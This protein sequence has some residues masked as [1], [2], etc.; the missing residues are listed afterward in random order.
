[1][2]TSTQLYKDALPFPHRR[3]TRVEV[4]HGGVRV[5]DSD[6]DP[7]LLPEA[8]SVSASLTSRV[9]RTMDLEVSPELYPSDPADLLSPYTAVL[10]VSSGIGYPDGS[11]E[12]FPVFTGRVLDV[13]R[14]ENGNVV[15]RCE[16]LAADVIG[17]QFEQPQ[18]SILGNPITSEIHRLILQALPS[19]TFGTDDVVDS[20]TPTLVWDE[21]RGQ[22]LDDLA[23]AVKA[24]WYA[25]GDG[26]FVIRR[27]PYTAGVPVA[28]LVDQSGGLVMTASRSVTRAG[29]ANSVTV[30]SERMDGTAPVRATARDNDP[31]SPTYFGG[32]YGKVSQII[33][34]QTPL[35]NSEAQ[36]LAIAQLAAC[37]AL[38]EQWSISCTPDHT[39]E[40][41]DTINASYRG[42]SAVQVI[43]RIT[44]PLT[45]EGP[46]ELQCRSS[47]PEPVIS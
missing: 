34:V 25:L 37:I 44:Y 45:T 5:G 46:M 18:P 29:S 8:G 35:T 15:L 41:G 22:A 9:T 16:D 39:L 13:D 40:P 6:T 32:D 10:K 4:Y 42:V 47:I 27:Y 43:D 31:S 7:R 24:R 20:T 38:T 26:S 3:E 11:R 33:K 14:A 28:S 17:F 2:L 30:V 36:S 21:D 12:I 23:Q 1:V 19:A